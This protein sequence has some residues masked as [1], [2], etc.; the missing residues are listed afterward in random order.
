MTDSWAAVD[1]N[2]PFVIN[3]RLPRSTNMSRFSARA[4][5][6]TLALALLSAC[7]SGT[8]TI[9][10]TS[11]STT[12]LTCTSSGQASPTWT[13]PWARSGTTPAI[14]SAAV[15]GDTFKLTFDTGTPDFELTP[16][17]SAHFNADSGLGQPIDLAGTAGVR[18]VLKGFRGDVNNYT[19][20]DSYTSEG[21]L[22]LQVHSLGGWE[23]EASWAAGLS[24]AG[25]ASVT[26][27][28]STL[29]FNFIPSP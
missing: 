29:T 24:R 14:V 11:S 8:H 25:C 13:A 12:T 5:T 6:V 27:A 23:G 28:G 20:P 2:H 15:S 21:H 10:Q 16:Q 17:S 19:G 18:I 1:S 22:L 9:A 3:W 7:G 26:A 4:F